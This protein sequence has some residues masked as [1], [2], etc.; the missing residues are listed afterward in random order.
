MSMAMKK[1]QVCTT[2]PMDLYASAKKNN[3]SFAQS[4]DIG[5]RKLLAMGEGEDPTQI[6]NQNVNELNARLRKMEDTMQRHV[7][8]RIQLQKELDELKDGKS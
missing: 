4:I 3:I 6:F 7:S 1:L 8:A 5:L 2:V